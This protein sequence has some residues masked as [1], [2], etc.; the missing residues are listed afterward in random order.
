MQNFAGTLSIQG[1]TSTLLEQNAIL[2]LAGFPDVNQAKNAATNFIQNVKGI[3][4]GTAVVVTGDAGSACDVV[5]ARGCAKV[6]EGLLGYLK[7]AL[8]VA[9]CV[10]AGSAGGLRWRK[11]LFRHVNGRR[12]LSATGDGPRL[13][14]TGTVSVLCGGDADVNWRDT[15]G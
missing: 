12:K 14:Y 1:S 13:S 11:L 2:L 5:E 9:L 6:G 3:V 15:H 4:S 10:G 7:D 8:S